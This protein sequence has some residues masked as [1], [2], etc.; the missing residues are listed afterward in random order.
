VSAYLRLLC[1]TVIASLL[2]LAA[3]GDDDDGPDTA[4]GPE[5]TLEAY[6][7]RLREIDADIATRAAVAQRDFRDAIG[8]LEGAVTDEEGNVAL[9]IALTQDNRDFTQEF[10]DDV[11]PLNPPDE[12]GDQHE[13]VLD[14]AR[15]L[16]TVYDE[17]ILPGLEGATTFVGA[18]EVFLSGGFEEAQARLDAA[19]NDIEAVA[20][21]TG[22]EL[23]LTCV[24]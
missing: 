24:Y 10:V 6:L 11:S 8:G 7:Q 21:E 20:T 19:C 14:A 9:L 4:S 3:C 13:E 15:D 2:L 22:T 23:L 5:R 12:V 1:I 16:L 18:N 17:T